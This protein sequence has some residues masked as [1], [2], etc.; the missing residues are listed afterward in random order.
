M[1]QKVMYQKF[2]NDF[3]INFMNKGFPAAHFTQNIAE[4]YRQKLQ[5]M[6]GSLYRLH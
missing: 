5:V 1:A 4:Q 2:G 3:L 6:E